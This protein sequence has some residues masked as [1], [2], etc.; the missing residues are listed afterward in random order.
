M[1]VALSSDGRGTRR[2]VQQG[3]F[4]QHLPRFADIDLD[5]GLP[6]L[7]TDFELTIQNNKGGVTWG[8]LFHENFP[9]THHYGLRLS[10][11]LLQ[12]GVGESGEQGRSSEII[13]VHRLCRYCRISAW[14]IDPSPTAVATR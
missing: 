2:L 3:H 11:Q 8:A 10:D 9:R 4:P 5:R 1:A 14:A 13:E 6:D 7:F 12:F